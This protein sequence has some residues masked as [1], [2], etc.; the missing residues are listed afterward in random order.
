MKYC[1]NR[2]QDRYLGPIL[3]ENDATPL[4]NM[5]RSFLGPKI[6]KN[7]THTHKT[8]QITKTKKNDKLIKI[9]P[10]IYLMH[11]LIYYYILTRTNILRGPQPCLLNSRKPPLPQ[12]CGDGHPTSGGGLTAR[13]ISVSAACQGKA[14][15]SMQG[16]R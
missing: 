5:F 14:D 3:W 12:L 15:V 9:K 16:C 2:V 1:L 4:N 7:N 13:P 8:T 11:L 6:R 10:T